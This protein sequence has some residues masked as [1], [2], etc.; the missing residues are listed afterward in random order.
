MKKKNSIKDITIRS[1]AAEYLTYISATG[2]QEQAVEMRYEDE[3]IWLTQKMIAEVYD[4]SIPAINQH[5][6]TLTKSGELDP[7]TIK[8]YLI[9]QKEGKRVV[10]RNVDH[11]NLQTIISVGFKIENE[12]AVQFRK[13]ARQIVKDYTIQG[14][15][16]DVERLKKGHMF[17][18]EYF[19]R[20]L[21]LIREIRLSERKFYQKVTDIYATAFDYDKS[22]QTTQEFFQLVQ[23]KLH[24]A[25]HRHTAAELI[26]ERANSDKDHMGLATWESAPD[27]KI[28]KADVTIAKNYLTKK[29]M[30]YLERIVSV[31]LDFAELQADRKIPMSME[32]WARRLDSFLEFNGNQILTSAGKISHERARLHAET[33]FE[34]YR[35]TQDK[36]FE[37]DFDRFLQLEE[38]SKSK[39]DKKA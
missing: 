4:V 30:S 8:Q 7:A 37:S 22:A 16:M 27:G 13:W 17:T 1:S 28:I 19:E 23:N 31:Y 2:N 35:V 3:N 25:V 18:D 15:S 6:D 32:D 36:L 12:R 10:Q 33:Q 21:Q 11:Y 38:A 34:E 39:K 9:V 26:V 5:L 24:F 29:E 20:Q 14:W